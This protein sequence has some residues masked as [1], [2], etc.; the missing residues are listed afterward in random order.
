MFHK[1]STNDLISKRNETKNDWVRSRIC[2]IERDHFYLEQES[3][4]CIKSK[5]SVFNKRN[6]GTI[7]IRLGF[8]SDT[9]LERLS[10][11]FDITTKYSLRDPGHHALSLKKVSIY[12]STFMYS[13]VWLVAPPPPP[14]LHP[15]APT[16]LRCPYYVHFSFQTAPFIQSHLFYSEYQLSDW[17]FQEKY[18]RVCYHPRW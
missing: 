16:S 13:H 3:R 10:F 4:F 12:L 6:S 2:L 15:A 1:L 5:Q 18:K 11:L 17:S 9:I 14:P 8:V 7:P